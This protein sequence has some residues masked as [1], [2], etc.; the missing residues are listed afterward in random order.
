MKKTAI[1]AAITAFLLAGCALGFNRH[2]N[3]VVVPA[4]PT[5]IEVDADQYYFQN[6][7]YYHHDNNV[8]VYSQSRQGPWN[9]LPRSHY[10]KEVHFRGHEEKNHDI[11]DQDNQRH[12]R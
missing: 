12:D 6:G 10:P 9:N 3:L 5:T 2:G 8:W 11:R 1:V 4:L 7:Y